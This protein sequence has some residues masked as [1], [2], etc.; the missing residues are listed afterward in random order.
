M[1]RTSRRKVSVAIL[2]TLSS[3]ALIVL[4]YTAF[5]SQPARW[6]PISCHYCTMQMP[7]AHPGVESVLKRFVADPY[8]NQISF[9]ARQVEIGDVI[10][11]CSQ[12]VCID[13]QLNQSRKFEGIKSRP[14][15]TLSD[16]D[17][18]GGVGSGSGRGSGQGVGRG[19][20]SDIGGGSYGGGGRTGT[21]TVGPGGPVP[22]LPKGSQEI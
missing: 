15:E 21:V 18:V 12:T 11:V 1:D 20:G 3:A 22:K 9:F 19:G 7:Y 8:P 2:A 10:T 16:A 13:Y 17:S 6:G 5:A 14:V 4:A